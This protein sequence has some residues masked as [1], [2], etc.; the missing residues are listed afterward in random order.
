MPSG[1]FATRSD[2][3]TATPTHGF[4]NSFCL[5][6]KKGNRETENKGFEM[7]HTERP[8]V[9]FVGG[10]AD[11]QWVVDPVNK[12]WKVPAL[13]LQIPEP[14]PLTPHNLGHT[15]EVGT[16]RR[17]RFETDTRGFDLYIDTDL[18]VAEAFAKLMKGYRP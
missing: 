8:K 10:V 12:Y 11:G 6:M 14:P 18:T 16:Y 4:R 3:P 15:V 5:T 2:L 7:N 1:T 17:E 9:M 13:R